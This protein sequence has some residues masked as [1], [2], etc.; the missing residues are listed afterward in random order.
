M[1]FI[2]DAQNSQVT[3]AVSEAPRVPRGPT[4]RFERRTVLGSPNSGTGRDWNRHRQIPSEGIAHAYFRRW[5]H[6]R[7]R[8]SFNGGG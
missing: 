6:S 1:R 8:L 7:R 2:C 5:P 3:P 4:F